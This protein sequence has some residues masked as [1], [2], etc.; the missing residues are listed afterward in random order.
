MTPLPDNADKATTAQWTQARPLRWVRLTHKQNAQGTWDRRWWYK[1]LGF[2]RL[3][4]WLIR[5]RLDKLAKHQPTPGVYE[6]THRRAAGM[7]EG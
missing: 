3:H 4:L 6:S 7:G 1:S 2:S 5:R